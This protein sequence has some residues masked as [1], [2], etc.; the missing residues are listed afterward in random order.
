MK[1]RFIHHILIPVADVERAATF[2]ENLGMERVPSLSSRIAWM[3]FGPNELH[4]WKHDDLHQYKGWEHEPSPHFA[5][6]GDDIWEFEQQIPEIGG[7]ILQAPQQ[8]PHDG[9]WYLFAL[10]PDG[11][12]FEVTQH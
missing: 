7:K 2:Y 10:D 11:N 6:E 3:K 9:S 4:L 12:R 8:R 5:V 1:I